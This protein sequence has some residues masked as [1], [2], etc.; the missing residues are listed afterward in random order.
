MK[1]R[2]IRYGFLC[3]AISLLLMISGCGGSSSNG[4]YAT[5]GGY[6]KEYAAADTVNY[7]TD[8]AYDYDEESVDY[9]VSTPESAPAEAKTSSEGSGLLADKIVRTCNMSAESTEY[10]NA[11]SAL[12][13]EIDAVGGL[14]E[15]ENEWEDSVYRPTVTGRGKRTIELTIRVPAGK[16]NT[17]L[18]SIAGL[19]SIHVTRRNMTV[20]NISAQYYDTDARREALN[21]QEERL[22]SMMEDAETVEDM[23]TI[24]SRLTDVEA[25]LN[26]VKNR[27]SLMDSKVNYS[28]IYLTLTE[29]VQYTEEIDPGSYDTF[30]YRLQEAL[31]DAKYNILS[32]LEGILFFVIRYGLVLI[33]LGLIIFGIIKVINAIRNRN[34]KG[35]ERR[36][37][38]ADKKAAAAALR[39][40]RKLQAGKGMDP[41]IQTPLYNEVTDQQKSQDAE[42]TSTENTP[43]DPAK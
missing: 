38:K 3:A 42:A 24:E 4:S 28:T 18:S 41:G 14:T 21:I 43:E 31:E 36:K 29:V 12:R 35:E 30:S 40:E 15:G 16:Y 27:L 10:E 11:L 20:E 6:A 33:C 5:T 34:G 19:G 26:Q 7:K 2:Q 1:N 32:F 17:F 13:K 23:I 22:L 37:A 25:E 39:R 9:D 8:Y